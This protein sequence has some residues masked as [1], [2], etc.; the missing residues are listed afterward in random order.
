MRIGIFEVH[1]LRRH[2]A[3]GRRELPWDMLLQDLS[4]AASAIIARVARGEV[5]DYLAEIAEQAGVPFSGPAEFVRGLH[6]EERM[7]WAC[8]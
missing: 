8:S 1:R 3:S 7:L 2:P 5:K 4:P 6:P